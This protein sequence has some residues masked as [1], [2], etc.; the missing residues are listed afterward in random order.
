MGAGGNRLEDIQDIGLSNPETGCLLYFDG[1]AWRNGGKR[2]AVTLVAGTKNVVFTIKEK[3]TN[4]YIVGLSG[5]AA[6]TFSWASPT[7][8]GFTINSSNA[9]STAIV[10]WQIAR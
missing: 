8:T 9:G 7:T 1:V 4:Y 10:H 5:N 6:E 3:D 2:G